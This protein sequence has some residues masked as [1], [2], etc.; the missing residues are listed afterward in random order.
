MST[1]DTLKHHRQKIRALVNEYNARNP[2]VF[3]S[4]L[5]GTE[6]EESDVDIL[7]EPLPHMS[8]FDLGAIQYE[9]SDMLGRRV[10][11]LTPDALPDHFRQQVLSQAKLI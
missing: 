6:H 5:T 1:L 2:S 9:L 7:I 11:V 10:D 3:G 4:V 8:L